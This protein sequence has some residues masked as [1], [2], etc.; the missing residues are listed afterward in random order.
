MIQYQSDHLNSKNQ[1]LS[2][3]EEN[4][5]KTE[6]KPIET[7]LTDEQL[8]QSLNKNIVKKFKKSVTP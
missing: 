7:P 2:G 6:L 4:V 3:A 5:P 1:P 8:K